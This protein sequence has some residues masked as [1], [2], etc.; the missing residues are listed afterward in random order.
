MNG[1]L[2]LAAVAA[3]FVGMVFLNNQ[4]D[5]RK[6]ARQARRPAPPAPVADLKLN[7]TRAQDLTQLGISIQVSSPG[8]VMLYAGTI[9]QGAPKWESL[10]L[11]VG[12]VFY[13][14]RRTGEPWSLALVQPARFLR[15][16]GAIRIDVVSL[17]VKDWRDWQDGATLRS[18]GPPT[19]F[20]ELSAARLLKTFARRSDLPWLP[21]QLAI[22]IE[23]HDPHASDLFPE[24][25]H[26]ARDGGL[27]E[28]WK[29]LETIEDRRPAT[30]RAF[31]GFAPERGLQ[32]FLP[33]SLAKLSP[34]Q[35]FFGLRGVQDAP[36]LESLLH[37]YA[38]LD[39]T[40]AQ[41]Q[42]LLELH[43]A[44][45]GVEVSLE[46]HVALLEGAQTIEE[47]LLAIEH[48]RR[49]IPSLAEG[50]SCLHAEDAVLADRPVKLSAERELA[51]WEEGVGPAF[52]KRSV[53]GRSVAQIVAGARERR[54]QHVAALIEASQDVP[55]R[56]GAGLSLLR[57][58]AHSPRTPDLESICLRWIAADGEIGA[59]A[60]RA[61]VWLIRG[62][63][64][65]NGASLAQAPGYARRA[66][67]TEAA[68]VLSGATRARLYLDLLETGAGAA[69]IE[70][71]LTALAASDRLTPH[72]LGVWC[73]LGTGPLELPSLA[74]IPTESLRE[75]FAHGELLDR[76]ARAGLISVLLGRAEDPALEAASLARATS[77][78]QDR[79]AV[80]QALERR[81][82]R[83]AL[84]SLTDGFQDASPE[85]QIEALRLAEAQGAGTST[86]QQLLIKALRSSNS[87]V[88]RAAAAG[89]AAFS[90]RPAVL[91]DLCEDAD[92]QVAHA[93]AEALLASDSGRA[94]RILLAWIRG[95]SSGHQLA[96]V[97]IAERARKAE[98][99]LRREVLILARDH[100]SDETARARAAELLR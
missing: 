51:R 60:A 1:A 81:D 85:V 45:A 50:L 52:L 15:A 53:G 65:V 61:L 49:V 68:H 16:E 94:R 100:A 88:R 24:L 55:L 12:T 22:L 39:L 11:E 99:K 28:T 37:Q 64:E 36:A 35:S 6:R 33:V 13:G 23:A 5:A 78:G 2:A 89:L 82:P 76:R 4:R 77:S 29:L 44:T 93:A 20:G 73:T 17:V 48:V 8:K 74:P 86:H 32:A 43:A 56:R 27:S 92:D 21:L 3:P 31:A 87:R 91:E 9:P 34:Y 41:A 57:L 84:S 7:G 25:D 69:E 42:S 46:Q 71:Q 95:G 96:A 70:R 79:T 38:L 97:E 58:A 59:N 98:A 40:P 90:Q 30:R 47:S 26:R 54:D 18:L 19:S 75:A 80:F 66:G 10:E 72:D 83:A 62:G 67:V 63:L 14:A